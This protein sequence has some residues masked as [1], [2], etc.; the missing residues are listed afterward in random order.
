MQTDS[1]SAMFFLLVM[2]IFYVKQN[3]NI[4]CFSFRYMRSSVALSPVLQTSVAIL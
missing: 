1:K 2:F 4:S 3:A